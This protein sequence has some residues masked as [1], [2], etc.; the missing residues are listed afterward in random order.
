VW[1]LAHE[2]GHALGIGHVDEPGAVMNALLHE[3]GELEPGRGRPVALA[4]A[5]RAALVALCGDECLG[6]AASPE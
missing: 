5:D 4:A 3:G 6:A 1:V 2:L